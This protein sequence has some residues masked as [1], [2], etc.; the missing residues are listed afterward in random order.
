MRTRG[1]LTREEAIKIVG[2]N[3]VEA[4]GHVKRNSTGIELAE[5]GLVEFVA[6]IDAIDVDGEAVIVSAYYYQP[7]EAMD[8]A[9]KGTVNLNWKISGYEVH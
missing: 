7:L 5:E 8:G 2:G 4:V 9:G 3:T 6:S 1:A